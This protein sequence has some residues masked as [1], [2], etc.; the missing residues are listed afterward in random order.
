M[1]ADVIASYID[2]LTEREFDAPFL[3]LLRLQ[4][5]T[6]IHFLHGPFEFGKDFIARRTET[7]QQYQYAFQTK[8][9]DIGLSEWSSCRGQIDML[10]TNSLAHPNFD[11]NL[12]RRAIFVTTGRLIGGAGLAAQ[13][14]KEHLERLGE[15]D[16]QTW[17]RDTLIEKLAIDPTSLSGSPLSLLQILG[18]QHENLNFTV[19]ERYSRGWIRSACNALHLR[20]SLEAAVI[21]SH[22]RRQNRADLACYTALMLLRSTIATAH[23]QF[24]LPDSAAVALSTARSQF[25]HY[26]MHLWAACQHR[27]LEPDAMVLSDPTP[28]FATYPVRCLTL[29]EILGL[30]AWLESEASDGD[31]LPSQIAEYL[32]RFVEAN[33]GT[34]HPISDR[35]GISLVPAILLFSKYGHSN[36]LRSLIR[37]TTK[38][39]ADRYDTG[40]FGLAEPQATPQEEVDYLLGPPFEHVPLVRRAE[41]YIGTLILDLTSVL[42]ESELFDLVRNEFLAVD[43]VLPVLEVNDDQGQYCIHMGRH[44]FEPNMPYEEHWSPSDGWKTAPHHR[45]GIA[46][47][48]PELVGTRWDQLAISSVLRDRHFVNNWRRLIGRSA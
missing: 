22:C 26:A 13:E 36:V 16:F 29:L 41:S 17:D 27:Y 34:S 43:I 46:L 23:G 19:L 1:L 45:R 11:K 25:R 44:S 48:Y 32:A 28:A 3:A 2:S 12:P 30:L 37:S 21:A 33:I 4:G 35:W 38:W 24:P 9:G 39:V 10:R 31:A 47:R 15:T 7:G 18:S 20:D 6:D 14:Y 8:A 5:F 42:E 40:N